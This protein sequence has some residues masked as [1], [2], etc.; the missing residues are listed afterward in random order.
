MSSLADT[1]ASSSRIQNLGHI[2]KGPPIDRSHFA[3]LSNHGYYSHTST[4]SKGTSAKK[5]IALT[6]L[7]L[8][9]FM[10]FLNIL[11]NCLQDQIIGQN[12][13]VMVLSSRLKQPKEADNRKDG[14]PQDS[15]S[16]V[17]IEETSNDEDKTYLQIAKRIL[18]T[19][20]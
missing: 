11:Q 10:F 20:V 15:Q 14:E 6:A 12:P 13:Q 18:D 9:A 2:P 17:N 1:L 5:S 16:S 19:K 3:D 7:T 4:Y 8:L